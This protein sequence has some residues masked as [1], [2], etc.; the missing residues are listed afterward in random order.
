MRPKESAFFFKA[1]PEFLERLKA[2]A[3]VLDLTASQIAREAIDEK[4]E[5]LSKK[6][7]RLAKALDEL[8]A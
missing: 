2:A 3:Y 4:I 5:K 1:S 8:V 6:N 7:P